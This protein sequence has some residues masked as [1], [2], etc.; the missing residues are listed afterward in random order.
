MTRI[1]HIIKSLGRGGAEM[2]LPESISIHNKNEFEFYC[3][4]FLP[5][6]NQMVPA[7]EATGC[8]VI[9]F[10][11]HTNI[12]LLLQARKVAAYVRR[13]NIS[14]IHAHLPW[15][16]VLARI[17][18]K[19]TGIPVLYTE[20]NKQERYHFA[21]RFL[22]LVT[23]N[24]LTGVI[25]VSQDVAQSIQRNKANLCIPLHTVLNGV[26]TDSFRPGIAD[27]KSIKASLGI[28]ESSLVI[29]TIAVFRFQKRLDLWLEIAR[30]IR[31]K[32][33]REC[34]FIIVGDGPLR[35]QLHAR[36]SELGIRDNVHFAGLQTEVRPF[37]AAFDIYMM[38]SIFEGL[39]IAMLE[40]M[41]SGCPIVTTDAGG[42]KEVIRHGQ[43][44][45][46][47]PIDN[48][49]RLVD[50]CI[51]L[52]DDKDTRTRLAQNARSRVVQSFG[53]EAMVSNL[54]NL[55]RKSAKRE[56]TTRTIE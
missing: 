12:H 32:F 13:N 42:I 37:L 10:S 30:L 50:L 53:M 49:L 31:D 1:L 16:G 17:V 46:L 15:A 41:S 48:P 56:I 4:Y 44:G 43:D 38:S 6:K 27:G 25:A 9:C 52:M 26:N 8:N 21:T 45:M 18:G 24:W 33:S 34:H 29:G 40:A 20:H 36:A 3:I 23:M 11:A 39:P 55:Y 28:P 14:L 19:L 51:Q 7:L 5:W 35:E 22:N 47:C 2:L 54:E